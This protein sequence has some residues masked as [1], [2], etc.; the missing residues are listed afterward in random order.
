MKIQNLQIIII[1]A[2]K[3]ILNKII[4]EKFPSPKKEIPIGYKRHTEQRKNI[5]SCK[6]KDQVTYKSK[7]IRIRQD[8][9]I[10]QVVLQL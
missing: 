2:Q 1:K 5:K 7:P 10:S 6:G 3:I 4:E 8:H 9:P